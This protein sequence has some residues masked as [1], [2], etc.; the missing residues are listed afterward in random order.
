MISY[1][2]DT[3]IVSYFLR[4]LSPALNT[5]MS[6]ALLSQEA[7]ISTLT[8][9]EIRYGQGLMAADDKRHTRIN[10]LLDEMPTLVWT[11]AAADHYGRIK[12][13]QKR[14]GQPVGELDTQI[15][16]RTLAEGLV[17]VTNNTRHFERVS[18]L[19]L[20]DWTA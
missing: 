3:N 5:R 20:E 2:L 1:L 17:L 14:Q 15:A 7:A 4:G 11:I 13:M 18:G 16:A 19:K 8:R 6:A 10:I 12:A 9:A